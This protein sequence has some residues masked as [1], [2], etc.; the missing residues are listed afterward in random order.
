RR[1]NGS[2]LLPVEEIE[3]HHLFEGEQR[4]LLVDDVIISSK[5]DSAHPRPDGLRVKPQT[6]FRYQY[7]NHLGS[8]CLELDHDTEIISYEEYHPYGTSAYRAV[9]SGIEAPPKRYRYTAMERDEES[10]LGYHGARYYAIWLGSWVSSDPASLRGGLNTYSYVSNDP[11]ANVDRSGTFKVDWARVGKG[12]LYAGIGIVVV[13][14]IILTAGALAGPVAGGIA[15]GLGKTAV[16]AGAWAT[17][18]T[19]V[20]EAGTLATVVYGAVEL[21]RTT[22]EVATEIATGKDSHT[23]GPI[24]EGDVSEKLGGALVGWAAVGLAS[25]FGPKGS[26]EVKVSRTETE[27]PAGTPARPT[28]P[29]APSAGRATLNGEPVPPT[30]KSTVYTGKSA[31]T[32]P[33]PNVIGKEGFKTS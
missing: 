23:G 31:D 9:K 4:V 28:L 1:Y 12:A 10:G 24:D 16:V 18:A 22:A 26:S 13:G 19:G 21:S 27:L 32:V 15:L 20:V 11:V 14:G 6:L 30:G 29:P 2:T 8:A 25:L 7:S 5:G 33:D 3:S 17:A